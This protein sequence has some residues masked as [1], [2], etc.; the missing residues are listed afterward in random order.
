VAYWADWRLWGLT[1]TDCGNIHINL[2]LPF[3]AGI[4]PPLK[5][6]QN[7]LTTPTRPKVNMVLISSGY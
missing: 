1:K 4:P 2:G 6:G 3:P 5:Y 7:R